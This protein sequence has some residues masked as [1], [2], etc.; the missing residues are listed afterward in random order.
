VDFNAVFST[1]FVVGYN[2]ERNICLFPP[3]IS[4]LPMSSMLSTQTGNLQADT[5]AGH[6]R[7]GYSQSH[8][9]M[10]A[11]LFVLL[12]VVFIWFY[13]LPFWHTDIWGHLAYGRVIWK[14]G[15]IPAT[16]P[17]MLLANDVPFIETAWLCKVGGFLAIKLGGM[18]ALHLLYAGGITLCAG[19][20]MQRVY[21]QTR[22][23]LTAVIAAVAFLSVSWQQL[24]IIRPQL[25]GLVCYVAL[26]VLLTKRQWKLLTWFAIPTLF[27]CWANLHGSFLSG[28]VM[29]ASFAA[30]ASL[31]AS[32]KQHRFRALV[33]NPAT[34]RYLLCLVIAI[35][36]IC[37]NPYGYHI[38]ENVWQIANHPNLQQLIEWQP[39]SLRL[40][41]G[42]AAAVVVGVLIVASYFSRKRISITQLI[43]LLGWG[44]AAM[45][46][47]R[48]ILWWAPVL[49][50]S[51]A[52]QLNAWAREQ[53]DR[54][55]SAQSIY[56]QRVFQSL[57]QPHRFVWWLCVVILLTGWF[58]MR[59]PNGFVFN[60]NNGT[61][62][63][64][65]YSVQTPVGIA[66]YFKEQP[67]KELVLNT[68]EW[69]D[70]LLW[71]APD[72]LNVIVASHAH[73]VP[74]EIWRDYLS[75]TRLRPGWSN[76]LDQYH[77]GYVVLNKYKHRAL[78]LQLKK[79]ADW[80]IQYEDDWGVIFNR[81]V[82]VQ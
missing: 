46:T 36:A 75:V 39:L 58:W 27:V 51:V 4:F 3:E 48:M 82:S 81:S 25:A 63:Q 73:L 2:I 66:E 1:L 28:L 52:L 64:R 18:I 67:T 20:L 78:M 26:F 5:T 59:S 70:Y 35:M 74:R 17:L 12:G 72:K 62:F 24:L 19:L 29:I 76:I 21:Q 33:A 45:W 16:E 9:L 31:E 23:S 69:G 13:H 68:Y 42:Q 43:L 71:A 57:H 61:A 11:G 77:F 8:W 55:I 14:T 15:R 80:N 41:Q 53:E 10:P 54:F 7:F 22:S 30:G 79:H 34:G 47:S 38:F 44:A 60:Q 65:G 49:A 56:L 50:Y 37:A 6:S 40:K 32:L